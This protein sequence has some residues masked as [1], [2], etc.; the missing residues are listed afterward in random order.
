MRALLLAVLLALAGPAPAQEV[1]AP[2]QDAAQE[3]ASTPDYERWQETAT[4]AEALSEAGRGS[5]F[6]LGR[7]RRD[8]LAWR[9]FF[10][11]AQEANAGRV[12]TVEAQIA[13]LGPVPAEGEPAED[14]DPL[15]AER[16][17]VLQAELARLRAPSRTKQR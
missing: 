10:E 5:A 16:R 14:E 7:L 4:R 15:I 3:G 9:E 17:Q 12:A 2:P 1:E 6:A 8:L 13:A 11:G